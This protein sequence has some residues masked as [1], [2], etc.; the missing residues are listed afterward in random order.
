MTDTP[1]F[2]NLLIKVIPDG[3]TLSLGSSQENNIN[4]LLD[5]IGLRLKTSV[6]CYRQLVKSFGTPERFYPEPRYFDGKDNPNK[7]RSPTDR[8]A[9]LQELDSLLLYLLKRIRLEDDPCGVAQAAKTVAEI[10]KMYQLGNRRIEMNVGNIK[11]ENPG[12]GAREY[13]AKWSTDKELVFGVETGVNGIANLVDKINQWGID[14]Q[15]T[16]PNGCTA[17]A[18]V[19]KLREE[20]DELECGITDQDDSKVVDGLGDCLVVLI[21]MHRLLQVNFEESLS[22]A[23]NDSKDRTGKMIDGMGGKYV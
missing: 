13:E 15:L 18:Q 9:I 20:I 1:D 2:K 14:R 10:I 12:H 16:R 5:Q 23:W 17:L 3:F 21:Q 7:S 6:A 8:V 19:K 11:P 4:I 22:Q